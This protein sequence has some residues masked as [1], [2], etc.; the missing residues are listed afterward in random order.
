MEEQEQKPTEAETT[1]ATEEKLGE[2]K[3][4]KKRGPKKKTSKPLI[5]CMRCGFEMS[6]PFR[7]VLYTLDVCWSCYAALATED[8]GNTIE[9]TTITC[10]PDRREERRGRVY[11]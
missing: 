6:R 7:R 3:E 2:P 9:K 1:C 11:R 10:W 5:P 8:E 4:E